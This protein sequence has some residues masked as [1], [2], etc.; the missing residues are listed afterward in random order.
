MFRANFRILALGNRDFI[1]NGGVEKGM[2]ENS[3]I[4]EP[5]KID[6]S[7]LDSASGREAHLYDKM[8][9]DMRTQNNQG[10]REQIMVHESLDGENELRKAIND[11]VPEDVIMAFKE[12]GIADTG[13]RLD[14]YCAEHGIKAVND[15]N[16]AQGEHNNASAPN[17]VNK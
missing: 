13:R 6:E 4:K 16:G 17:R 12:A 5:M 11:T 3:N 15:P 14:N 7:A 9:L 2:G 8:V 10:V 1:G